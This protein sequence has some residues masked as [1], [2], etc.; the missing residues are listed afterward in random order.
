MNIRQAIQKTQSISSGETPDEMTC[1]PSENHQQTK[2]QEEK[3]PLYFEIRDFTKT[4][5][6]KKCL[7][8]ALKLLS[9]K[10]YS[11]FKMNK[12]L[13]DKDHN[14]EIVK[15]TI[16]FLILKDWLK[17]DLYTE[18]RIKA[19]MRK[20]CSPSFIKQKLSQEEIYVET[21]EVLHIFHEYQIS[22]FDQVL[23][24]IDKKLRTSLHKKDPQKI[25]TSLYRYLRTK[26]H[27]D[28][29]IHEGLRERG[30]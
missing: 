2:D 11:S 9:M 25:K 15:E 28:G 7:G 20:G 29:E 14:R 30:I 10:D 19:F 1:S 3:S 6:H 5:D 21:E 26:G 13:L 4:E 18:A 23:T 8:D 24:L 22:S 27:N 16:D 12:K 17:E